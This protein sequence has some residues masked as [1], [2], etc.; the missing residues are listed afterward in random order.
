[1]LYI[2]DDL[3][4]EEYPDEMERI[5]NLVA[6]RRRWYE[7]VVDLQKRVWELEVQLEACKSGMGA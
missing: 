2:V 3:L 6:D 7:M 5:S 4:Y 1:M